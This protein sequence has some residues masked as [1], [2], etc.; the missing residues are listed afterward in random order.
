MEEKN[1]EYK[2]FSITIHPQSHKG[3]STK[4]FFRVTKN[5][6]SQFTH[7]Q[8]ITGTESRDIST[9]TL[10]ELLEE[11]GIKNIQSRIDNNNFSKG[12]EYESYSSNRSD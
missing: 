8:T 2:G 3:D 12:T 9:N 7:W 6:I 5:E 10:M 4:V 1:V 11:D